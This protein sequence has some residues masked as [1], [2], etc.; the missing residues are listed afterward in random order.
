MITKYYRSIILWWNWHNWDD[1]LAVRIKH[2][3]YQIS[4][5]WKNPHEL[6]STD[7][8]NCR[9]RFSLNSLDLFILTILV[10]H[11][12]ISPENVI[13]NYSYRISFYVNIQWPKKLLRQIKVFSTAIVLPKLPQYQ[14]DKE[15]NLHLW[16]LVIFF[17]RK[18][19]ARLKIFHCDF[20]LNLNKDEI[21][22]KAVS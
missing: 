18:G 13:I 19:W 22:L 9:S 5:I 15:T 11:C 10:H 14:T 1:P 8:D 7:L 12:L 6:L 20:N 4:F 17:Q 21:L 2:P 16:R 3:W